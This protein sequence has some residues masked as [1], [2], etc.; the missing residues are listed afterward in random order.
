MDLCL[1]G[2][3]EIRKYSILQESKVLASGVDKMC[4]A[5]G[6]LTAWCSHADV[7]FISICDV[8]FCVSQ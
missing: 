8:I 1:V 7:N 3:K 4:L 5:L 6:K 2:Q